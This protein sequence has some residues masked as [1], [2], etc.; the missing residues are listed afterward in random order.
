[1]KT[2]GD[3]VEM[4]GKVAESETP[5]FTAG[6]RDEVADAEVEQID[7]D[8]VDKLGLVGDQ[9]EGLVLKAGEEEIFTYLIKYNLQR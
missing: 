6:K 8:Q 5:T 4:M 9:G 2:F 3:K 1:M 7:G